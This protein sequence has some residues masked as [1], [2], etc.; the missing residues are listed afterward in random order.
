MEWACRGSQNDLRPSQGKGVL[1]LI[2]RE[3]AFNLL[4]CFIQSVKLFRQGKG[5]LPNQ[6]LEYKGCE[7][8]IFGKG[9]R[10]IIPSCKPIIASLDEGS[11][12]L[13]M[14]CGCKKLS[15]NTQLPYFGQHEV[16]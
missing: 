16:S 13:V 10:I 14:A 7:L 3:L 5:H 2:G 11:A 8:A 12:Y 4:S 6:T 15:R 1:K 9:Q